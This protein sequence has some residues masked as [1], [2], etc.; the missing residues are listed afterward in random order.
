MWKQ[1]EWQALPFSKLQPEIP[2]LIYF[3]IKVL[4]LHLWKL[5]MKIPQ[6][7][8]NMNIPHFS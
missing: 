7:I 1:Y 3:G 4:G 8:V 6:A 2:S 5:K